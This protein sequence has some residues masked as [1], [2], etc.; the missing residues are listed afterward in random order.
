[1]DKKQVKKP[2]NHNYSTAA[3]LYI[4]AFIFLYSASTI[5]DPGSRIF[6]YFASGMAI[7]L[8]TI[9]VAKDIFK[10]GKKEEFD[11]SGTDKAT[12][13]F[14][15]LFAYITVA[16][17]VGY[18]IATPF[19]LIFSM[20]ALGQKS[21]KV[22]ILCAIFVTLFIYLFFDLALEMKIPAGRFFD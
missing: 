1:M 12:K 20:K 22:M 19:Y 17:F 9:M 16:S 5:S 3:F 13:Y 21:Y 11:F 10:I 18:Y 15:M 8:A 4:W 7:L 2:F 6:P 14:G